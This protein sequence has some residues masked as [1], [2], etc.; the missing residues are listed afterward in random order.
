[1][2]KIVQN[3]VKHF[4]SGYSFR[5]KVEQVNNGGLRVIQ[6]KDVDYHSGVIMNDLLEIDYHTINDK[7]HLQEGDVLLLAKGANNYAFLV[8][9]IEYPAIA[10]SAFFVLRVDRAKV[11]PAFLVWQIN[12]GGPQQYLKDRRA[13]TYIPNVNKA[14][15]LN[16]PIELPKLEQQK[17]IAKIAGLS[18]QEQILQQ[19]IITKRNQMIHTLLNQ[20]LS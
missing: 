15:L 12:N 16:M 1:M 10:S 5:G 17:K 9:N 13:G 20:S 4:A 19:Q 3:I 14:E 8:A 18:L 11:D 6:M 2:Q 7:Y